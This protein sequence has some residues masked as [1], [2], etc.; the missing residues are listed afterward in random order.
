MVAA[1]CSGSN[2]DPE[3]DAPG[4][5]EAAEDVAAAQ[6][7]SAPFAAYVVGPVADAVAVIVLDHGELNGF[8]VTMVALD[9]GYLLSQIVDSPSINSEGSLVGVAPAG[10]AL[11]QFDSVGPTGLRSVPSAPSTPP[12]DRLSVLFGLTLQEIHEDAATKLGEQVAAEI[13]ATRDADAEKAAAAAAGA[14]GARVLAVVL[15]LLAQ[16]YDFEQVIQGIIF[17]DYE[18]GGGAACARLAEPPAGTRIDGLAPECVI[19]FDD[20]PPAPTTDPAA[21][22]PPVDNAQAATEFEEARYV[23][24]GSFEETGDGTLFGGFNE[25]GEAD[26]PPSEVLI[27]VADFIAGDMLSG[28]FEVLANVNLLGELDCFYLSYTFDNI[29]LVG[30]GTQTY[31][32]TAAGVGAFPDEVCVGGPPTTGL[33]SGAVDVLGE[34]VGDTLTI[35]LSAEGEDEPFVF[36]AIRVES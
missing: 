12:A 34:V 36:T 29:A 13:S 33:Q 14:E 9:S 26:G 3:T 27:D 19:E 25:D 35:T 22:G 11:G 2:A 28:L 30:D 24:V 20:E 10:P 17:G 21:A 8:A 18:T 6:T 4:S 1:S 5:T 15:L 16:G 32:G 7:S 23:G 31:S